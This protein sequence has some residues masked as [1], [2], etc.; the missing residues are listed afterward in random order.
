VGKK[1]NNRKRASGKALK[2]IDD[3]K[4]SCTGCWKGRREQVK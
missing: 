1:H 3:E 2:P 4:L